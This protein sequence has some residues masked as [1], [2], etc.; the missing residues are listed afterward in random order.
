MPKATS[1]IEIHRI[2]TDPSASFWI[3]HALETAMQRD[4]VDAAF[5]AEILAD[6]L[7]KRADEFSNGKKS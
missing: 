7:G 3:K 2:L 6:I 4:P 5:D 1:A